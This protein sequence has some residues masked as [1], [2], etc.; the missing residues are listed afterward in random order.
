VQQIIRAYEEYDV[1]H[2]GYAQRN[3]GAHAGMNSGMNAA[4]GK[5]DRR[6]KEEA[7]EVA[8]EPAQKHGPGSGHDAK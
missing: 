1:A 5:G 2:P 6:L 8:A 4:N 7:K 3:S